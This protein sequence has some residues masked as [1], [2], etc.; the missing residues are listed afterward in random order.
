MVDWLVI[1]FYCVSTLLGLFNAKLNFKQFSL[2]W[3]EFFVYKKLNVKTVLLKT[4]Q[5]SISTQFQ[6][7]KQ[8]Y[9]KQFS[10]TEVHSL[11]L[12]DPWIGANQVLLLQVR[13]DLGVMAMK[14]YSAFP[15]RLFSVISRTLVG[16]GVLSLCRDAVGVFCN[17][18]QLDK[19]LFWQQVII[20]I[21]IGSKSTELFFS[22]SYAFFSLAFLL[23]SFYQ[24]SIN[25]EVDQSSAPKHFQSY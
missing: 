16:R 18:T 14:R 17:T 8:F 22:W 7:Q 1:L 2:V 9:F 19:S 21:Q 25:S 6:C 12:F 20:F 3:V 10:S 11:V 23:V 13:V 15:I 4:I 5:F 24:G